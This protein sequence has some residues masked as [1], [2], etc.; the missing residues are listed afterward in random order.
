MILAY[1]F[2]HCL[3]LT[4]ILFDEASPTLLVHPRTHMFV[5]RHVASKAHHLV[6]P[7]EISLCKQPTISSVF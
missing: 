2:D 4:L 7:N 3:M 1:A 5:Y 6:K